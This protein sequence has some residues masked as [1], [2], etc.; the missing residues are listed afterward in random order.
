MLG[1]LISNY[2]NS[3]IFRKNPFSNLDNIVN[4]ITLFPVAVIYVLHFLVSFLVY[5]FALVIMNYLS[6]H[7]LIDRRNIGELTGE[8]MPVLF[9]FIQIVTAIFVIIQTAITYLATK[10]ILKIN[11]D[12]NRY[13]ISLIYVSAVLIWLWVTFFFLNSILAPLLIM[14]IIFL[15]FIYR[16]YTSARVMLHVSKTFACSITTW[17]FIWWVYMFVMQLI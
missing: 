11:L 3:L 17:P 9:V 4:K 1:A 16:N 6:N 15:C 13:I 14:V 10:F 8:A 7:E 5:I 2:F 12:I